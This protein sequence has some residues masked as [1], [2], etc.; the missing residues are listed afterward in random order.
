MIKINII[1]TK[2]VALGIIGFL[3][4]PSM[5]FAATLMSVPF[6]PQAPFGNWA[7]PWQEFCEEASVV[8]AAHFLLGTP[9]TPARAEAEMQIV[10]QYEQIVFKKYKDTSAEETASILK[11]LYGFKNISTKRISSA[12]EITK[13]LSQGRIVIVPAAG[14]LLKNPNFKAPGPLYHMLVIKGF[15]SAKRAFIVND[16]GTRRGNG[17]VYDQ[18]VLVNAIHDWNGGDVL[19]GEKIVI[20]AGR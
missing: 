4:I 14:R 8:M 2:K 18:D 11:N 13:E 1:H 16:P 12:S 19:R 6:T 7:M 3:A 20:V 5:S 10:R 9:L 15:D 17:Y